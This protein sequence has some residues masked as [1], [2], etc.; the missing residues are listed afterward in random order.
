MEMSKGMKQ[1]IELMK[2][3]ANIMIKLKECDSCE[4][5]RNYKKNG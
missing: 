5:N 2:E 4:S 3:H 1:L